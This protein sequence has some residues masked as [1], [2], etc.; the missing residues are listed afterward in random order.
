MRSNLFALGITVTILNTYAF[1]QEP[2][3]FGALLIFIS[4]SIAVYNSG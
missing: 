1:W 3:M 4:V 2:S